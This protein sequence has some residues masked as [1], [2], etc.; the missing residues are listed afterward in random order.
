M[1]ASWTTLAL[2][3][4]LLVSAM[5]A[6]AQPGLRSDTEFQVRLGVFIPS[7]DSNFWD[8]TT[9]VFT[10]DESDFDA[11]MLG[12]SAVHSLSNHI[13]IGGNID[14][15]EQTELSE[16]RD[17]ED[18]DGFAILHDTQ[19]EMVPITVDVRFVPGGRYRIRPGGRQILKPMF[20][21][22][23]GLGMNLWEY[24][25]VGDFI[26]F[27]EFGDPIDIFFADFRDDGAAFEAHVLAGAEFPVGP[28]T[29]LL[30]EGRYSWSDDTLGGD[31]ADLAFRNLDLGGYSFFAGWTFRF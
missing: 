13:E 4:V 12:L 19:L 8:D 18:I 23:A 14:F 2:I 1:K 29:N 10:L 5:P 27:D 3:L 25:E 31:F 26:E 17:F 16:Y 7:G 11:F 21:V 28:S 30:I 9:S 22:G 15:Y 6:L 24:E 20:Y